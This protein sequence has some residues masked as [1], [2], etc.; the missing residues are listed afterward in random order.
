MYGL[1]EEPVVPAGCPYASLFPVA[2]TAYA[3]LVP[4]RSEP[5]RSKRSVSLP[6]QCYGK[7]SRML[8]TISSHWRRPS[9]SS[10]RQAALTVNT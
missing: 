10:A 8:L 1:A 6:V 9:A 2:V 4:V 5:C 3:L 7:C